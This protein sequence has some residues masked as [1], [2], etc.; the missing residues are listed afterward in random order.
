MINPEIKKIQKLLA[1]NDL[2]GAENLCRNA[3]QRNS[4]D[5]NMIALLGALLLKSGQLN[6]ASRNLRRAI[7]LAPTFAK[8]HE[9]LAVVH[10]RRDEFKQAESRFRRAVELQP[11]MGTAW[12][13][14]VHAL[15]MQDKFAQAGSICAR[16]LARNPGNLQAM[17]YL[18]KVQ[19]QEGR[20]HEA[21]QLLQR[22]VDKTPD[23]VTALSD[24]AQFHADQYQYPRAIELFRR[25]ANTQPQNPRLHFSL[26]SLLF[27]TGFPAESLDACE[28]GLA[29]D[30]KS[31]QGRSTRAH[32]LRTLGRTKEVIADYKANIREDIN[33][34]ESWW[35]LASLRT[36]AFSDG[37]IEAMQLL[38]SVANTQDRLFIDFALGKAMDDREQ[39]DAAWKHYEAANHARRKQVDYDGAQFKSQIDAIMSCVDSNLISAATASTKPI[40][41][42]IFILGMP[43]SGSTLIEQILACH[44][45]VEATTELPY[46]TALGEHNLIVE[47]PGIDPIIAGLGA[48]RLKAIGDSYMQAVQQHRSAESPYFIDKMPDNFQFAGLIAM[49]LPGARIID[50]R[51]N[52]MDTSIG[53]FRQWFGNGKEYSYDLNELGNRYLQYLRIMR[54]WDEVMPGKILRVDYEDVVADTEG[55]TRRILSWCGLE[56]EEGCKR[57][58]ESG[59]AVTTASSEQVRQP[60]YKSGVGFWK[61]YRTHLGELAGVLQAVIK[62]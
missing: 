12:M 14:L 49:A 19:L 40:A 23:S 15:W 25:A 57:F 21:G 48:D 52:P 42:P 18:A 13:G 43:R 38:R 8:P 45:M 58:Y 37:D 47:K 59:R 1:T 22:I 24:L 33:T 31:P 3:V 20:V 60:I 39:Y 36:Y 11:N 62:Q 55:E 6:E 54:H 7:E 32:A 46:M 53:N 29:L 34:G 16:I 50:A 27:T 17:R 41:T 26:A 4:Y 30:P 44:S 28:A 10:L 51:R 9:D 5:V 56:W 35:N 61:N 2:R